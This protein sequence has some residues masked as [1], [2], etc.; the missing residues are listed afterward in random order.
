M[1]FCDP[2]GGARDSFTAAVAHMESDV[3]ILD[4]LIEVRA[5]FNPTSATEQVAQVLRTYGCTRTTGDRYSAQWVVEAFAKCG[6]AYEHSERDRSAIYLDALPLFTSGRARLLDSRRLVTQFA[7]LERRTS[8]VGKDRVD[9]GPGGADDLC[10]SVAGALVAAVSQAA[11]LWQRS[12]LLVDGEGV[13]DPGRCDCAFAVLISTPS[14]DAACAYF[15]STRFSKVPLTLLDFECGPLSP[16]FFANVVARLGDLSKSTRA[17][18]N[19]LYTSSP[20]AAELERSHRLRAEV[21]DGIIDEDD[22]ALALAAA[23][24]ITSGRVKLGTAALSSAEKHPLSLLDAGSS[25]ESDDPLRKAAL[26]GVAL[27][28]DHGRSLHMRSAA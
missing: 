14:G 10:N 5:P 26:V 17:F 9:H 24:H 4:C 6:I 27:A 25:D 21:A 8:P 12:A 16:A 23:V 11:S 15:A 2:S 1:S 20:L 7:G 18:R 3:A 19:M 13:P 22:Q 28:L